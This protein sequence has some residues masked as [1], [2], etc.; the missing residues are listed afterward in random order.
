[1]ISVTAIPSSFSPIVVRNLIALAAIEAA[2]RAAPVVLCLL[3]VI[4]VAVVAMSVVVAASSG[5]KPESGVASI[6]QDQ[7]LFQVY[8][9]PC[10]TRFPNFSGEGGCH[11]W[12]EVVLLLLI[13]LGF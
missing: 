4:A 10:I 13:P 8:G 6:F 12:G 1:M 3:L 11:S 2:L 9:F 5:V 7:L